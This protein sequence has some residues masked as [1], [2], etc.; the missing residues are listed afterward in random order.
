MD[1]RVACRAVD[2]WTIGKFRNFVFCLNTGTE[3]TRTNFL[4]LGRNI[5]VCEPNRQINRLRFATVHNVRRALKSTIAAVRRTR[6]TRQCLPLVV[7]WLR[8]YVV[9][10]ARR[11]RTGGVR[12]EHGLRRRIGRASYCAAD[13]SALP[14]HDYVYV[15]VRQF[16]LI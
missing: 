11:Q 6:V 1:G 16:M 8:T 12:T 5:L 7:A 13:A 15:R 10:A 14:V 3:N 2:G 4:C 9:D